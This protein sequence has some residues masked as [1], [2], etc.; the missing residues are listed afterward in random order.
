LK[1]KDDGPGIDPA[2]LPKIFSP[3]YTSKDTGTGLGLAISKRLALAM[4]GDVSVAS[5]LGE[6]STFRFVVP[7]RRAEAADAGPAADASAERSG[8]LA[9]EHPLRILLAEDNRVNQKVALRLLERLGYTPDLAEN[10]AE[11]LAALDRT[12]YDVVLMDVQMPGIDGLEATR[13]IRAATSRPQ[14]RVVALTANVLAGEREACREAG[15]DDYVSKP[16]DRAAL[17][18]ALRR[19]PVGPAARGT[20]TA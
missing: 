3:F 17:V 15:M 16:I 18:A 10:G 12:A 7:L 6:G 13:R 19:C 14:P 4:G 2:R 8:P 11:V 20:G 5:V 1:V 9:A